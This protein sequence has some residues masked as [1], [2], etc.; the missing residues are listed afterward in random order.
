MP[1]SCHWPFPWEWPVTASWHESLFS[2]LLIIAM[3]N[4]RED[5]GTERQK[6]EWKREDR[7]EREKQGERISTHG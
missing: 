2:L 7:K 1:A 5:R 4:R 3:I 6:Q